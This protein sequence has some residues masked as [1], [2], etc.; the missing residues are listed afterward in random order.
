MRKLRRTNAAIGL[1][2]LLSVLGVI[3]F[4]CFSGPRIT[5]VGNL[6]R[7]D[8]AQIKTAVHRHITTALPRRHLSW[9][10]MFVQRSIPDTRHPIMWI[11]AMPDGTVRVW[12]RVNAAEG[13]RVGMWYI[14]GEHRWGEADCIL[15]R[16]PKGWV[17]R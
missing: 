13:A 16:G 11:A 2:L 15:V 7:R 12:Y 17:I 10:P 4:Y 8:I 3:G 9:L 14:G 1:L 5:I 6:S